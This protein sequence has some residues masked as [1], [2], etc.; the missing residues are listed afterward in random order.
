[1]RY[2]CLRYG[3]CLALTAI[4]PTTASWAAPAD[5]PE[6]IQEDAKIYGKEIHA[7]PDDGRNV[8]VV[9]GDF[10]LTLGDRVLRGRDAVLWVRTYRFGS[11]MRHEMTVYISGDAR[12]SEPDMGTATDREMLATLRFQGRLGT[13]GKISRKPL[14]GF[15]LYV[16]AKAALQ[17]SLD[18]TAVKKAS[19]AV[20]RPPPSLVVRKPGTTTRPKPKP[21]PKV[22]KP[23]PT[24]KKPKEPKPPRPVT[25]E[26][27]KFSSRMKGPSRITIAKDGVYLSQ[28]NPHGDL[29]L[30]LRSQSGVIFSMPRGKGELPKKDTRSPF[31]GQMGSG[32]LGTGR[33]TITGVYLEGDVI[34]S[35]GERTMTGSVAYYDFI[36]DR[37]IVLDVVFRAVQ[38]QRNIPIWL[39]AS[40]ARML[41]S[42]ESWFKDAKVSTSDFHTP[43]YHI[44]AKSTYVFDQTKY[45]EDGVRM[46]EYTWLAKMKHATMNVRGVPVAYSP[47]TRETFTDGHTALRKL[48]V[49]RDSDY[50]AGVQSEWHL[51]RLLGLVRPK[52]FQGKFSFDVYQRQ[53]AAGVDLKYARQTYTGYSKIEGLIDN[54][55]ADDFGREVRNVDAPKQRGRVLARHKQFLPEDWQLQFELS[56]LCDRNYLRQFHPD[57]FRAGK[58]QETLLYAKKQRDNWAFDALLKYRINRFQEYPESLPDLGL[59]LIGEPLWGDRLTFYSESHAGVERYRYPNSTKRD[60]SDFFD[61]LDTRQEIAMP[62]RAGPIN[63]MPYAVGRLSHW[64]D[65]PAGGGELRPYGQVGAKANIHMWRVYNN[66]ESRLWDVHRL[67]HVMTPE[68]TALVSGAGNVRPPDLYPMD[69]D[70]EGIDGLG[71]A[72]FALRNVL[73]T[74]RGP[75]DDRKNVDWMRLDLSLGFYGNTDARVP[76]DGRFFWYRP[77]HS[78]GRNHLNMD[79]EW[80]ISDTTLFQ[81]YWNY[82]LDR[83]IFGRAGASI[84][85]RRSPRLSYLLGFRSVHDMDSSVITGG[86]SYQLNRKYTLSLFEQYDVDYRGGRNVSTTFTITRRLP[87]WYVALS[88]QYD[89]ID[90]A[91]SAYLTI[92]PEG[93]PEFEIGTGR[94]TVLGRST[95]N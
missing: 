77:E 19:T 21:R 56:Y 86:V 75:A 51:F 73:Q 60:D 13:A 18:P 27:G 44:G 48:Q 81:T 33:E 28:G 59:Y 37:A 85:V 32:A 71:G 92:W 82:D 40:E 55:Q 79:Y 10:Y 34:I 24:R 20:R 70:I 15:P 8:T 39:R 68:V 1:M 93:V 88:L 78:L 90:N 61:R 50:G 83:G 87:R 80:Q 14:T 36:T 12:V 23:A 42:R 31:S 53:V 57:E 7:F 69:S 38:E 26:A 29:F 45:D 41:S 22:E 16:R 65:T 63:L 17:E 89:E 76:S 64:G 49:G 58:E 6:Y 43:T 47:Y 84:A 52:G 95:E 35:R 2:S 11:A 4:V 9:L 94:M 62:L 46:S 91:M 67:K 3:I 25:L 72:V 5:Q 66:V 54:E 74:K 30:E